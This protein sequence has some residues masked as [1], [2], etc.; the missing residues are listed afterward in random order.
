LAATGKTVVKVVDAPAGS[1]GES[2]DAVKVYVGVTLFSL[3]TG[4]S[5]F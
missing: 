5:L 3:P 2:H 4:F 1:N